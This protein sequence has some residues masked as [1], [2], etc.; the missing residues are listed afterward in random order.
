[1]VS[2][3]KQTGFTLLELLT[4]AAIL[5]TLASIAV[6]AY[7]QYSQRARFSEAILATTPYKNAIEVAAFR[8]TVA[9]PAQLN[10][11]QNGIPAMIVP[12][13]GGNQNQLVGVFGGIIVVL[14]WFDGSPLEGHTYTMQALNID[15]PIRWQMGGSCFTEGWC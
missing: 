4:V 8:G 10:S 12:A 15:P 1:M 2:K 13:F 14:W 5:G 7:Q 11:G 3:H 9:N 6:P